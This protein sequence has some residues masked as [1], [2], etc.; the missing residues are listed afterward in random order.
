M[1]KKDA[2]EPNFILK[3]TKVAPAAHFSYVRV[4]LDGMASETFL[5][6]KELREQDASARK[7]ALT[8]TLS[9]EGKLWK[10][11]EA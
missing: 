6:L 1:T 8:L 2:R 5:K 10:S 11:H 9:A 4:I 7:C 3:I